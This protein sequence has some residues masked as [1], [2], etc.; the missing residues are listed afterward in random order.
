MDASRNLGWRPPEDALAIEAVVV[1]FGAYVGRLVVP[2][3]RLGSRPDV[4][5]GALR[6]IARRWHGQVVEGFSEDRAP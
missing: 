1:R 5:E 4:S 6:V 2:H 3:A